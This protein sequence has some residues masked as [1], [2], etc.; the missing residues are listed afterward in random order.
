MVHAADPDLASLALL[1]LME[2]VRET[3]AHAEITGLAEACP[4]WRLLAR[5]LL[6]RAIGEVGGDQPC[7]VLGRGSARVLQASQLVG[8]RGIGKL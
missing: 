6:E 5:P 3:A 7:S 1:S 2:V 8:G 4:E